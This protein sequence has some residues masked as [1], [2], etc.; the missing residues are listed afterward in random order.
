MKIEQERVNN[1]GRFFITENN[2]TLAE[3]I[4]NLP[5]KDTMLITHTEVDESLSGHG[6]GKQLLTAAV[7]YARQNH[8]IIKATCKFAK[9]ILEKTPAYN[10]V[11]RK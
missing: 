11:Y 7:D 10:D 5:E 8:L 3:M 2:E 1:G 9:A 6:I 4:Y